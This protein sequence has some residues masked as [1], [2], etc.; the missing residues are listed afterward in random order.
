VLLGG[1]QLFS[2]K[3]A[4]TSQ[5]VMSSRIWSRTIPTHNCDVLVT[6][7]SS[8]GDDVL[9]WVL[10]RLHARVPELTVHVRHH[11]STG[12][13]GFYLTAS[14]EKYVV[15]CQEVVKRVIAY[16]GFILNTSKRKLLH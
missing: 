4:A 8:V 3:F 15:N 6:F 10:A 11:T 5:F 12:I 16:L 2:K 7:D 9:M 13:Y 14:F 1:Q